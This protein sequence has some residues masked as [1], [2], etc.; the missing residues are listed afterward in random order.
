MKKIGIRGPA[1]I[2][3]VPLERIQESYRQ[4]NTRNPYVNEI[5]LRTRKTAPFSFVDNCFFKVIFIQ[6]IPVRPL[7]SRGPWGIAPVAP[8]VVTALG[9]TKDH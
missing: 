3:V 5:S 4:I 8:V 2:L 6:G 7:A 9:N 1:K